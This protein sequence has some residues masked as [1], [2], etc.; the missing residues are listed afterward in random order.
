MVTVET[1]ES[2]C[3]TMGP[4]PTRA[5]LVTCNM[6]QQC[7][8]ILAL[9]LGLAPGTHGIAVVKRDRNSKCLKQVE[10]GLAFNDSSELSILGSLAVLELALD[11]HVDPDDHRQIT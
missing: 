8:G 2:E 11:G 7:I 9:F 1:W 4:G 5:D 3:W 10:H 6:Y